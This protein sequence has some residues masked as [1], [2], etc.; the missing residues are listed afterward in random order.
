MQKQPVRKLTKR[1]LDREWEAK[2]WML[3]L[4]WQVAKVVKGETEKAHDL[5]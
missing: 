2:P 3:L 1:E 5:H 4:P